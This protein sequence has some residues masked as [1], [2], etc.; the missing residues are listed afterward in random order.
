M[1]L[2]PFFLSLLYVALRATQQLNVVFHRVVWII[3]VSYGM[4]LCDVLLVG[5][6][7]VAAV[8]A[9]SFWEKAWLV[10]Q[11]GTGGAVGAIFSMILHKRMRGK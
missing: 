2:A 11:I 9:V 10:F 7:A 8:N 4:A 6:I 5:F 1:T 3:P